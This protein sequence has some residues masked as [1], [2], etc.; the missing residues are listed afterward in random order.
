MEI[1]ENLVMNL[2]PEKLGPQ[3]IICLNEEQMDH[4]CKLLFSVH[5]VRCQDCPRVAPAYDTI[6]DPLALVVI[7]GMTT[8]ALPAKERKREDSR[9]VLPREE[10]HTS[11]LNEWLIIWE[12]ESKDR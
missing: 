1:Y 10:R 2:S 8:V 9:E 11:T 5:S 7:T 4:H 12:N 3:K 6:L